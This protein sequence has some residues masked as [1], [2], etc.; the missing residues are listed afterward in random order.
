VGFLNSPLG[1]GGDRVFVLP[2]KCCI[3]TIREKPLLLKLLSRILLLGLLTA[4]AVEGLAQLPFHTLPQSNLRIKKVAVIADSVLLDTLSIIPKTFSIQQVDTATYQLDFVKAVLHWKTKPQSDSILITYRVFPYKLNSVVQRLTYESVMNNIYIAPY[5]F[6]ANDAES[7]KTVF[8]FGNIQYN[9]SFGRSLS[10]G[11]NQDAVVNSTFQL[12][13]NGMLADSIEI[14]AALTDNN[15][16]I[17]PDGTTQQLNE[18]D[19]VFLQF[20]KKNWQLNLGDIDIRQSNMY[21]LNFY[22][23]L[24]GISFQTTNKISPS[25]QST[26]LVSGSIAKGK[27]TRNIFQ[28]L[29]GN[30]GP[31]RLT[32]ANNEF[33]FIVLANTERVY[34]DGELLQ[35]GEDRDYT[36]N[37]NTAEVT[38]MP[39]RMITKDSRIQIEFEYA[40]RNYL[41][42]N[43]YAYQ[44]IGINDKLKLRISAFN[45]SD[46]KNSQINQTLDDRQ[47]QFLFEV[48]DSIGKALYP[49][50]GI[51]SFAKDKILYERVY[52]S[53][54]SVVDSFYR[55]SVDSSLARYSLSFTDLG[56]GR[57]NYIPDFNGANGKV[58]RYVTP[59]NGIKQGRFEPV[60]VLVT[61][62]KQQ[63]ISFGA[64]YHIDKNNLLKT[65]FALSN[66]D[67]N[68]FSSKDGGDDKGIAARIQ[69]S[70]TASLNNRGLQL[71]SNFDYEHVQEKFKPLERLRQVEFSREWGLPLVVQPVTEN[72]LRLSTGIKDKK[73]QALTYQ[74][75]SYQRS[76]DYKGYQNIVQQTSNWK[77][78]SFNNQLAVTNYKNAQNKGMYLRPV[79]DLSKQLKQLASLR[80]GFKYALERNE[81]RNKFNDSLAFSSFSFD[82]YSAYLKTDENRKN[83]YALTFYTR[84]DKYPTL[85]ELTKGDRSYNV[86]FQAEVLQS[87]RHQVLFNATYRVLKVY[88]KTVSKQND[89]KTILGRTEYL[90]NEWK[91]LVTGN[92]L[93]ELGTGQEQRRDFAYLEV[94]AG[95]GEYTWNDYDSNGIQTLN[96]FEIAVFQD[97]AKFIRIFI[98]TNEFTKAAYTTLN[99]SFNFNPKAVLNSSEISGFG[100][101]IARFNWQTSMQKT[102]KSIAK[103]DFEFNPFKY[104]INDTALLTLNT[105]FLN[106]VSFNRFSSKWGIDISNLQNTGKALLTY[107]YESRKMNDWISKIRWNISSSLSF[108]VNAKKGVTALF[109]PNF[110][111]RNYE[112]NIDNVEP[113]F[114]FVKGTVFRIQTSYKFE[115]K[116]NKPEYGGEKSLSN[117]LNLE[118]KY[119]VLQNSS[120]TAK[121]TYNNINY[122]YPANTTVSYIM[123]DGLLPGSNYLWSVDLTK[124]LINNIE[125]NF[126]YE[127]RKPGDART[128]HVGRAAIRALF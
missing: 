36:I 16:P 79:I 46:A 102:K 124:R 5:E 42:A 51:D 14:A 29:E 38:F 95:Q 47:K 114:S 88:D 127:G 15:I 99:Y 12:Q 86:N 49:T 81:V 107:G 108:D 69:Y 45:N 119:N 44:E 118:T 40:D 74:F 96:E 48:G 11:N 39:K 9:G 115:Q 109:T 92:V 62:K 128:V 21:F 87:S 4:I 126:Q 19:Q 72:I 18:F 89:D 112:L 121:F 85:K 13:L 65:E 58:F 20:K 63:L 37:Y 56:E 57:G 97:Q 30:Q 35:R 98:P 120:I 100:K 94:P 116:K 34:I 105:S 117:A 103:G 22:K 122:N 25:L 82:T 70:N 10:F 78:W 71:I 50:I 104:G 55:Y 26:T 125:L 93:Y 106:T 2:L 7:S 52:D 28:G 68:T 64:D 17:Q 84:A 66:N 67:V 76:D 59:V 83:K 75:M 61:P 60:M 80:L 43:L 1:D 123:L 24:Q 91:G 33:F 32:G 8:D 77:G 27:F 73:N 23:R 113:R 101:F 3:F 54:G 111:N 53:S 90:I 6:N 31:Y 110:S 41:N